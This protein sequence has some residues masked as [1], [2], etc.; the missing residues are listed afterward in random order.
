MALPPRKFF[1]LVEVAARWGCHASDIVGWA[2]ENRLQILA[3]IPIVTTSQRICSGLVIVQAHDILGSFKRNALLPE[4]VIIH[5]F[6]ETETAEWLTITDP[7]SG[8]VLQS[9]DL[10]LTRE[11]MEAF[12]DEHELLR[13]IETRGGSA[14][15]WDWEGMF[16]YLVRRVHDEGMPSTQVELAKECEDWFASNSANA[17]APDLRTIQRKLAPLFQSIAA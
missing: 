6:R 10:L 8:V 15:R 16:C 4:S 1:S 5:R 12:E 11:A 9:A 3:S 14:P 2:S 13:R 7:R 17:A